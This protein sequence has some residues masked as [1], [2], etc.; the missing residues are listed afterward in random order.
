[1]KMMPWS[2]NVLNEMG[3]TMMVFGIGICAVSFVWLMIVHFWKGWIS[4]S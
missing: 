3:F 4:V 1:M 2:F